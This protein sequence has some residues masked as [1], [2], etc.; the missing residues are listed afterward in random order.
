MGAAGM[1]GYV[2][3]LN[4]QPQ[5]LQ[6]PK[7]EGE[8]PTAAETPTVASGMA[9]R[10]VREATTEG[11]SPSEGQTPSAG[12]PPTVVE[13]RPP[14][15]A[16]PLIAPTEGETPSAAPH[17]PND[18]EPPAVG[19]STPHTEDATPYARLGF[20]APTVGQTPTEASS[21]SAAQWPA[22][23]V[24]TPEAAGTII[25]S[26]PTLV[27]P[28]VG[29]SPSEGVT[30]PPVPYFQP[31]ASQT[32]T[33]GPL[34]SVGISR[35]A[36]RERVFRATSVQHGHSSGEQNLFQAMWSAPEARIESSDARLLT[37]GYDSLARLANLNEKS[38][39]HAIRALLAK[40]AL[41]I[42]APE[43]C[44]LRLGRTYRIFSYRKVLERREAAGLLWVRK[45]RGV[46]FI[47]A[48]ADSPTVGLS[49]QA[50]TGTPGQTPTAAV[51]QT[52]TPTVGQSP[53]PLST[54]SSTSFPGTAQETPS[55]SIVQ[56]LRGCA[57]AP[58]DDAARRLS[59][60]CRRRAPDA[61]DEEI[62]H[63]IHLKAQ[64][65]GIRLPIGFLLTA[66]PRCFEGES[67]RQYRREEDRRRQALAREQAQIRLA[68]QEILDDPDSTEELRQEARKAL[69]GQGNGA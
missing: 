66:V 2:S 14:R 45:T 4:V 21:A 17:A 51:G 24:S 6:R 19:V 5:D 65:P 58:D 57:G 26:R 8:T 1:S 18:V 44:D 16:A 34:P 28:T 11:Q 10:P 13:I 63:F 23:G 33:V 46:E 30:T 31:G 49:L 69:A 41:E 60:E 25:H 50:P 7:A 15:L 61:T 43:K 68:W 67:F 48:P 29:V 9:A 64:T 54:I 38:V 27:S 40:L 22:V 35:T 39:R 52:P 62:L 53:T 55:P 56:A 47:A 20:E 32:P 42:A 59:R 37:A 36:G 3:F 12:Q